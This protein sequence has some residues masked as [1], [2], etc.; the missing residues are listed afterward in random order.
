MFTKVIKIFDSGKRQGLYEAN[1]KLFTL[2]LE[3]VGNCFDAHSLWDHKYGSSQDIVQINSQ[4]NDFRLKKALDL[5]RRTF[6]MADGKSMQKV[7]KVFTDVI[8]WIPENNWQ[9]EMEVGAG[10]ILMLADT[11]ANFHMDDFKSELFGER[12]P[13][14]VVMPDTTLLGDELVFQF[15]MGVYV[16][17]IDETPVAEVVFQMEGQAGW[18]KLPEW[19]F[20]NEGELVHKPAGIYKNQQGMS[21]GADRAWA[22]IRIGSDPEQPS[23]WFSHQKGAV[24]INYALKNMNFAFGDGEYIS[25]KSEILSRDDETDEVVFRFKDKHHIPEDIDDITRALLVK[26]TA[27]RT[28]E[29]VEAV[30]DV[31]LTSGEKMASDETQGSE[32]QIVENKIPE[33]SRS[34]D[35]IKVKEVSKGFKTIILD[36]KAGHHD[37]GVPDKPYMFLEG[38]ALPRIDILKVDGLKSWVIW[39]DKEGRVEENRA[40]GE[41]KN[42]LVAISASSSKKGL[43]V[44]IPGDSEFSLINKF[45]WNPDTSD[46]HI[47]EIVSLPE[48][49]YYHGVL[50]IPDPDQYFTFDEKPLTL[51]R[52]EHVDIRMDL[53]K[54]PDFLHWE[55]GR[56]MAGA[57]LGLINLSRTHARLKL[58]NENLNVV[59][60]SDGSPLFVVKAN[61]TLQKID[62]GSDNAALIKPGERLLM[63]CCLLCFENP[64]ADDRQTDF[65]VTLFCEQHDM[66]TKLAQYEKKTDLTHEDKAVLKSLSEVILRHGHEKNISAFSPEEYIKD[67]D[68][69]EKSLEI[70]QGREQEI[71]AVKDAKLFYLKSFK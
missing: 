56:Q 26:V 11:L 14:Y 66:E 39:L 20:W 1:I 30:P 64:V 19:V 15:G 68:V 44:K 51:G 42:N 57:Y 61:Q 59:N 33:P 31:K 35:T 62:P 9:N 49:N 22:A 2:S 37:G 12:K 28:I 4:K 23:S 8:L 58:D 6:T 54:N 52:D 36:R 67:L 5:Y 18:Q 45:P 34:P 48:N 71:K 13:R 50:Q 24:F 21:I 47:T 17:D 3:N 60:I 29:D 7:E 46:G 16:P 32:I 40:D 10:N 43:F 25:R 38:V 41:L 55:E 63:G 70:F 65:S 69:L 27:I 53:L